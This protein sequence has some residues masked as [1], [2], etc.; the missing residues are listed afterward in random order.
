MGH[1]EPAPRDSAPDWSP[2][3]DAASHDQF[4]SLVHTVVERAG[5]TGN[6]EDDGRTLRLQDGDDVDLRLDLRTLAVLCR[7]APRDEWAAV[8]VAHLE[9]LVAPDPM[10]A[11]VDDPDALRESVRV[12]LYATAALDEQHVAPP[13]REVADGLSEVVVVDTPD[14]VMVVDTDRFEVLGLSDAELLALGRD[15]LRA[16]EPVEL[17]HHT[18]GPVELLVAES[19]NFYTATWALLLDEVVEVP[20]EGALVVIPSRHALMVHPLRDADAVKA[21]Q[22]LLGVAHQH[23]AE[24]PGNLTPDLFWY[25]DGRLRLLPAVEQDDGQLGF[26]PPDDFMEVLNGLVDG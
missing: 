21:V 9:P 12:R 14:T 26:A 15:N 13:V 22:V 16:H 18:T 4:V 24:A 19:D 8:I 11:L 3:P 17:Q 25:R 1:D 6:A 23:F 7:D 5:L 2:L 10:D 20:P